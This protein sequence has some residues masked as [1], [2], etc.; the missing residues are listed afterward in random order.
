[1]VI[2][3]VQKDKYFIILYEAINYCCSV[4]VEYCHS[5]MEPVERSHCHIDLVCGHIRTCTSSASWN[6]YRKL[7]GNITYENMI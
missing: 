3:L 5:H 1:M 2:L 6:I 7:V 4:T